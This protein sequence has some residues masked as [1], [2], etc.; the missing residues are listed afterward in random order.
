MNFSIQKSIFTV[1]KR[2]ILYFLICISWTMVQAEDYQETIKLANEAY[3]NEDYEAAIEGYEKVSSAGKEAF[4]LYFN[5]GNAYYKNHNMPAA[6][7]NY[8]R[9]K[10][11]NPDDEDLLANLEMATRFNTDRLEVVP[12]LEVSKWYRSFVQSFPADLWA[13]F[14]IIAFILMLLAA[15]AF[16]YIDKVGLRKV[17]LGLGIA[18]FLSSTLTL[19][20]GFQEK[21]YASNTAEAI[22][23]QPTVTVSSSPDANGT[24]LFI[25][26]E[27]IKV[28]I[29]EKSGGYTKIKLSDGNVGW[30]KS[31]AIEVI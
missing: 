25:I 17:F 23:F 27:G 15:S 5:L 14:S 19:F 29:V 13:T 30:L 12:T 16:L 6:I 21:G 28:S 24:D 2:S 4:E 9:A 8:E 7:L 20:W 11:I 10:K 3:S 18:F 26:H 1:M 31:E 22:V